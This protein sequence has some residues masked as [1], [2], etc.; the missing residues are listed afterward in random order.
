[1]KKRL[2]NKGYSLVEIIVVIAIM[3]VGI[4]AFSV[5]LVTIASNNARA[6]GNSLDVLISKAKTN[7]L[8]N[9]PLVYLRVAVEGDNIVADIYENGSSSS[10]GV[11]LV[12]REVIGPS[13]VPV[14]LT[15]FHITSAQFAGGTPLI[16]IF[17]RGTGEM[18][19]VLEVGSGLGAKLPLIPPDASTRPQIR[20]GNPAGR[21]FV[22][23]LVAPTGGHEFASG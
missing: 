10:S 13:S 15:G 23:N 17:D 6:V 1:M 4:G 21:N 3:A 8:Y 11:R 14:T 2:H 7:S 5:S 19:Q 18:Y 20:L 12:P 22:I 9:T 16:L